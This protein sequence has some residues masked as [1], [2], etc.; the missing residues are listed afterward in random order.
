[1]SRPRVVW[2]CFAVCFLVVLGVMGWVTSHALRLE[3]ARR[4]TVRERAVE[5]RLRLALWRLDSAAGGLL[6]LENA[7]PPAHFKAFHAADQLYTNAF[8]LVQ[9]GQVMAPSPMLNEVPPHAKLYFQ[10]D[11]EGIFSSPQV[12]EGNHRDLAEQNY[13]T[14]EA[15]EA[16]QIW[17]G[18]ARDQW[19]GSTFLSGGADS[20]SETLQTGEANSPP[21]P[22][23]P[24][25]ADDEE[26]AAARQE[27]LR[28]AR[29][30]SSNQAEASVN[31]G[32]AKLQTK[33]TLALQQAVSAG[34]NVER[35]D[36]A[37]LY[38]GV[39]RDG[40]LYLRR[41]AFLD[42]SR[43]AQFVW[44]EAS[45]IEETFLSQIRDLFPEG[46]LVPRGEDPASSLWATGGMSAL[47]RS[48]VALPYKLDPGKV[49]DLVPEW[50][51]SPVGRSLVMAWVSVIG[52]ALGACFLVAG[53]VALSE[54]RAA[55]VSAVTHE[56]RTPLTTF[57][58]YSE[59]LSRDMVREPE[60][61][62][63][64]LNTL[65]TEADRLSHLVENVLTYARL[66]RGRT[67]AENECVS[68]TDLVARLRPRLE[69]RV[70]Q[71]GC[72]LEVAVG[73]ETKREKLRTDV[74]AVE[75]IIF[76]LVDNACKYGCQ[77]GSKET[78][79]LRVGVEGREAVF[80]VA[81]GGPGVPKSEA[82]RLF[83]PFQKSAHEAAHSA[84]GIGLGLGLCRQLSRKL[85]GDVRLE[86]TERGACFR[87]SLPLEAPPEQ[88]PA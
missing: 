77:G 45:A 29:L 24:P 51:D 88:G 21:V 38:T 59:M 69:Q 40:E 42:G 78:V 64:Y 7:R 72:A 12:P 79:H 31:L 66:E 68:L 17:L 3:E 5:A 1:M 62:E 48:L 70:V 10:I 22:P 16:A 57:R 73:E 26:D 34:V 11:D 81:D 2:T 65:T 14:R 23:P 80:H 30:A 13:T 39:W 33:N 43:A 53:I 84:P 86:E 50:P 19:R 85:G 20:P 82:R 75:Q 18:E 9:K 6:L 46:K 36:A 32:S 56:M 44:L 67:R 54:R 8:Q 15:I 4:E 52:A 28:R 25:R 60:K 47:S 61:R 71:D 49:M 27:F 63:R 55:F 87:L 76:N 83:R 41:E 74:M 37:D 58:L 35:P